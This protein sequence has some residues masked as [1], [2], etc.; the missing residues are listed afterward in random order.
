MTVEE[1]LA[2]HAVDPATL[3]PAPTDCSEA[4][5]C[6]RYDLHGQLPCS[7]CGLPGDCRTSRVIATAHGPRWVDL[8]REHSLAVMQGWRGPAT[9][10]GIL[11]DL[12]EVAAEV[13]MPLRVWTDE[14]GWPDEA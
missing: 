14:D 5:R 6:A 3:D 9:P 11:A 12:R 7:A 1:L 10:A 8:C 13:G 4:I 2:R